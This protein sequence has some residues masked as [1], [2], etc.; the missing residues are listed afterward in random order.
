VKQFGVVPPQTNARLLIYLT[1]SLPDL[2]PDKQVLLRWAK[3]VGPDAGRAAA[4]AYYR[5]GDAPLA[6]QTF[7]ELPLGSGRRA[8]DLLFLAMA[9]HRARRPREA[10][11]CLAQAQN[12]I[13]AAERARTDPFARPGPRWMDWYERTQVE[14]L[15]REA[16]ALLRQ[17]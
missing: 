13:G 14:A 17:P 2:I 8:W 15:R 4:A 6:I 10:E 11:D 9:H 5:A 16:E 12:W 1:V 7:Q 3:R